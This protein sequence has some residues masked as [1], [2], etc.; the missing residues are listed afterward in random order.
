M[1]DLPSTRSP[2]TCIGLPSTGAGAF[3][4]A[5]IRRD[6]RGCHLAGD[7]LLNRFPASLHCTITWFLE[8]EVDQVSC[9]GQPQ[10]GRLPRCAVNGCQTH[11]VTSRSCGDVHAFMAVFYPDAFHAL[12][13]IDLAL[14]QNRSTDARQVLPPDG[15]ELIDAVFEACSD[16]ERQHLVERFV[17]AHG[18]AATMTKWM[19]IRRMADRMTLTLASAMLGVGPRQLQRLALREAGVNLQTLIRLSRGERGFLS[20]QRQQLSGKPV[21]WADHAI[22]SD[23]ADQSHMARECKT[24]TGRTPAQLARDVQRE[25]ADWIY[26]LEFT[27]DED[28][29]T[30][31]SA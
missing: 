10:H 16:D 3:V 5:F 13:G 24:Q 19:R 22:A 14:L 20:A 27:Y 29:T 30:S 11:P 23:Y 9:G 18:Q 7:Q 12:F 2:T 17:L 28:C 8:G 25:E 1:R 21:S 26:R 4:R 15:L 6:T 31:R